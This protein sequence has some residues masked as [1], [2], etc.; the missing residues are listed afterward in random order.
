MGGK[1]YGRRVVGDVGYADRLGMGDEVA[2]QPFAT[3]QGADLFP[4]AG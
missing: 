4:L 1:A 3:R 2:E